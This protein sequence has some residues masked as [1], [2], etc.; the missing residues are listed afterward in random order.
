[1]KIIL[2]I[3]SLLIMTNSFAQLPVWV[4]VAEKPETKLIVQQTYTKDE[5][6][7]KY[8]KLVNYTSFYDDEVHEATVQILEFDCLVVET[9]SDK[10]NQFNFGCEGLEL[11][12]ECWDMTI[13]IG[14][15]VNKYRNLSP[16]KAYHIENFGDH[17]TLMVTIN[18][19]EADIQ[20]KLYF[21]D[22]QKIKSIEWFV[23]I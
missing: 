3:I 1:M 21:N 13:K 16:D 22:N 23:P 5:I 8:G 15:D 9:I 19:N 4:Q 6:I 2:S 10:V 11:R 14:E 20:L 12:M 18:G 17:L 7:A